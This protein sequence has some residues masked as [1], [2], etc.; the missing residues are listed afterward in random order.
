MHCLIKERFSIRLKRA[1][2][3]IN[4]KKRI[5]SK[6]FRS[7]ESLMEFGIRKSYIVFDVIVYF[8]LSLAWKSTEY[9]R[10]LNCE[11]LSLFLG[12]YIDNRIQLLNHDFE[13]MKFGFQ[14]DRI[15]RDWTKNSRTEYSMKAHVIACCRWFFPDKQ[16]T[17][18][19]V[20]DCT[21]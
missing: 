11:W 15:R 13:S 19:G 9:Y 8:S 17:R 2:S 12:I 18:S 20:Y 5:F 10:W 1:I 21:M 7:F 3:E 14:K 4:R 16:C 6:N